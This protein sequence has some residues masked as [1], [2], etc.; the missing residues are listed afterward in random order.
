[1]GHWAYWLI[2]KFGI[3]GAD[4]K[5]KICH[6]EPEK[7]DLH[8]SV[9]ASLRSNPRLV[10]IKVINYDTFPG[11]GDCFTSFAMTPSQDWASQARNDVVAKA[12]QF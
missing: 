9:I 6:C 4:P 2:S 12:G 5:V 8:K 11:L 1:M 10:K 7:Q 3:L